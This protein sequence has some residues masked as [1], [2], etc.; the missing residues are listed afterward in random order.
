MHLYFRRGCFVVSHT[1]TGVVGGQARTRSA[2]GTGGTRL[3]G[4]VCILWCHQASAFCMPDASA[5]HAF[6]GCCA[7]CLAQFWQRTRGVPRAWLL[8]GAGIRHVRPCAV[9]AAAL[10][11]LH[12]GGALAIL[13]FLNKFL[14]LHFGSWMDRVLHHALTGSGVC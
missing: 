5:C 9:R 11:A 4:E 14:K 12:A 2:A 3:G 13:K 7:W 6:G 1:R 8:A 10:P